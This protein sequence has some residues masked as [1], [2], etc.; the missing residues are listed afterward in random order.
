MLY[1]GTGA[2]TTKPRDLIDTW[3][4]KPAEVEKPLSVMLS[5]NGRLFIFYIL[6]KV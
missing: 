1:F 6:N 5:N 4:Y 2:Y 3:P